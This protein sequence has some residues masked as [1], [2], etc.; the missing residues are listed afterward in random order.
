MRSVDAEQ[1]LFNIA[2]LDQRIEL[3]LTGRRVPLQLL[4]LFAACALLLAAIGI[5][6][7]LAFSVEQRTS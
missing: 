1:P 7:V 4:A 5:Y 2:T 6:G 3:S